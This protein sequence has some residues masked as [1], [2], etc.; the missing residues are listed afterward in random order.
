MRPVVL[1]RVPVASASGSSRE[2]EPVRGARDGDS[3][4]RFCRQAAN[5][6]TAR[7]RSKECTRRGLLMQDDDAIGGQSAETA[8]TSVGVGIRFAGESVLVLRSNH[9]HLENE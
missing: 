7:T 1:P 9:A 6:S 3:A 4:V 2:A 8:R 5:A